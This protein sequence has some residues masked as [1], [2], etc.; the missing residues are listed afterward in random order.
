M[1]LADARITP[2]PSAFQGLDL[3]LLPTAPPGISLLSSSFA[4]SG[5]TVS[6]SALEVAELVRRARPRYA[7]WADGEGFWERE[8]FGWQA[9][10]GGEERW[11][12]AVKL[13]QL[14]AEG[15]AKKA[16]VS[17]R[18]LPYGKGLR[19]QTDL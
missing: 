11:T 19:I 2:L 7:F 10:G 14:G 6:Q 17:Y 12:R 13:G 18:W 8:P 15:T 9:A 4:S 3:L 5:V 16:R 1:S